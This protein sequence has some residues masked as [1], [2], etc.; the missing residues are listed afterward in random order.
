MD[1]VEVLKWVF[2]VLVAGFIGYFGK[3][4]AKVI[5]VRFQKKEKMLS[6]KETKLKKK[7]LKLEKKR[8]KLEKKGKI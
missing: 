8:K 2:I 1:I 7:E 3:Y 4:M 6:E 5:I